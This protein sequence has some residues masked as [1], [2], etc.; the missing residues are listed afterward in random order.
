MSYNAAK[1]NTQTSLLSL[2]PI[3][4]P[5][6]SRQR[7]SY[8]FAD[9]SILLNLRLS[10]YKPLYLRLQASLRRRYKNKRCRLLDTFLLRWSLRRE[11]DST[12]E[13]G[14]PIPNKKAQDDKSEQ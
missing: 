9:F 1:A 7:A 3:L 13:V 14:E 6:S 5:F 10:P 12:D 11:R 2:Q 8:P 4:L